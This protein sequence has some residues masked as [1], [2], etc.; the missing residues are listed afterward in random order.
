MCPSRWVSPDKKMSPPI[1]KPCLCLVTDRHLCHSDP[2]VLEERVVRAVEGGVN[3]V[4]L[5]EKDLPGGQ[6]LSLAK[7]LQRV[8][9]GSALLFINERVDV[10]MA[11]GADGVQL[12]EHAMPVETASSLVGNG[13]LIGR[14]VHDLQ[15][16]LAAESQ[17]ADLLIVGTVFPTDSHA[18]LHSSGTEVLSRICA[19]AKIPCIGIGG[20]S[21]LN[22][23]EVIDAGASGVAVIRAILA[24]ED[25]ARAASELRDAIDAAWLRREERHGAVRR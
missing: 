13:M 14:S 19:A 23:G 7:R 6:L 9:E 11:S 5:R 24:A 20:I 17:G 18:G 2:D 22:A 1:P 15:G 3:L 4:Q 21:P 10:A 8:T 12:G 16:A 25:S